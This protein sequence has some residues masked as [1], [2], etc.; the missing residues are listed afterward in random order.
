MLE[1]WC[2]ASEKAVLF[3][4][5]IPGQFY[6]EVT[7]CNPSETILLAI[8]FRVVFSLVFDPDFDQ[9]DINFRRY[10]IFLTL[11]LMINGPLQPGFGL[12]QRLVPPWYNPIRIIK[13]EVP[14]HWLFELDKGDSLRLF[15]SIRAAGALTR[16]RASLPKRVLHWVMIIS[17]SA[18]KNCT[19]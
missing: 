18:S 16:V 19:V 4:E 2:A 7:F 13:V 6:S 5:R 10:L 12:R 8:L 9:S 15:I 1:S 17:L 3:S 14:S 11:L